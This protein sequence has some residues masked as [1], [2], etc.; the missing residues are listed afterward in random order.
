MAGSA[1]GRGR[2][3]EGSDYLFAPL[4]SRPASELKATFSPGPRKALN[5]RNESSEQLGSAEQ[6][7]RRGSSSTS[8]EGDVHQGVDQA[9]APG[10]VSSLSAPSVTG[11]LPP[12]ALWA[13]AGAYDPPRLATIA[14]CLPA[15]DK[16]NAAPPAPASSGPST[17]PAAPSGGGAVYRSVRSAK[18]RRATWKRASSMDAGGGGDAEERAIQDVLREGGPSASDDP[19]TAPSSPQPQLEAEG[20][21]RQVAGAVHQEQADGDVPLASI[22]VQLQQ[23]S[24]EVPLPALASRSAPPSLV[25]PPPRSSEDSDAPIPMASGMVQHVVPVGGSVPSTAPASLRSSSRPPTDSSAGGGTGTASVRSLE[26][27]E[28]ALRPQGQPRLDMQQ[29]GDLLMGTSTLTAAVLSTLWPEGILGDADSEGEEDEFVGGDV[30]SSS[31]QQNS[32]GAL[33]AMRGFLLEEFK[34]LAHL[35]TFVAFVP[36]KPGA[37]GAAE[38][39]AGGGRCDSGFPSLQG[40]GEGHSSDDGSVSECPSDCS[41]SC[42]CSGSECSGSGDEYDGHSS[43]EEEGGGVPPHDAH[44]QAHAPDIIT[45]RSISEGSSASSAVGPSPLAA[46]ARRQ[47][48]HSR[49]ALSPPPS[50][51]Q[52]TTPDTL[53]FARTTGVLGLPDSRPL[54]PEAAGSGGRHGDSTPPHNSVRLMRT[55]SAPIATPSRSPATPSSPFIGSPAAAFLL[56]AAH[57]STSS[58]TGVGGPSRGAGAVSPDGTPVVDASPVPARRASG[59]SPLQHPSLGRAHSSPDGAA[60]GAATTPHAPRPSP[61]AVAALGSVMSPPMIPS[62]FQTDPDA[63]LGSLSLGHSA[64]ASPAIQ[65][66]HAL[67]FG[68]GSAF[69]SARASGNSPAGRFSSRSNSLSP[70]QHAAPSA[71]SSDSPS[72]S[73][74]PSASPPGEAPLPQQRPSPGPSP[75]LQFHTGPTPPRSALH[76]LEHG[77]GDGSPQAA[78]GRV[79][80]CTPPPPSLQ[81]ARVPLSN[82]TGSNS[83]SP[84]HEGP[85]SPPSEATAPGPGG[86]SPPPPVK[87]R[88]RARSCSFDGTDMAPLGDAA[89]SPPPMPLKIDVGSAHVPLVASGSYTEEGSDACVTVPPSPRTLLQAMVPV[90][91]ALADG[92]AADTAPAPAMLIASMAVSSAINIASPPAPI[93]VPVVHEYS[94]AADT[95]NTAKEHTP[96]PPEVAALPLRVHTP[97]AALPE[98]HDF[99][100]G[101]NTPPALMDSASSLAVQRGEGCDR[102][103]NDTPGTP[104]AAAGGDAAGGAGG[105]WRANGARGALRSTPAGTPAGAARS[106]SGLLGSAS[107]LSGAL[108]GASPAAPVG[109]WM[110][111]KSFWEAFGQRV[112]GRWMWE[113]VDEPRGMHS[114]RF[115]VLKASFLRLPVYRLWITKALAEVSADHLESFLRDL[116]MRRQFGQALVRSREATAAGRMGGRRIVGKLGDGSYLVELLVFCTKRVSQE[117]QEVTPASPPGTN[118]WLTAQLELLARAL[119]NCARTRPLLDNH[120]D[121]LCDSIGDMVPARPHIALVLLQ[122][123]QSAWPKKDAGREVQ[124]LSITKT[125][126]LACPAPIVTAQRNL[127]RGMMRRV[128]DCLQ[129]DHAAVVRSALDFISNMYI[130]LYYLL[131]SAGTQQAVQR[132]LVANRSHWS[133]EV[134]EAS[135]VQFDQLL[136]YAY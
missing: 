18:G 131:P 114:Q 74:A 14:Q 127:T 91:A 93:T 32:Y 5:F 23:A 81:P 70:T 76:A 65:G 96:P 36:A 135:E 40:R 107:A 102:D 73:A 67:R 59:A 37:G 51:L 10:Q 83:G 71:A 111:T 117:C 62:P 103:W 60:A 99:G 110:P 90:S 15:F 41:G 19:D 45:A 126:L 115:E 136:E 112:L 128:I 11:A 2:D 34:T 52:G 28:E 100:A 88:G 113:I 39:A 97:P 121:A 120:F 119:V 124:W 47:L 26:E 8:D 86:L 22:P 78:L 63:P 24:D 4:P 89:V 20:T 30:F 49:S 68:G 84:P 108:P 53:P 106:D 125:V 98:E 75:V 95:G 42:C 79:G 61:Q 31:A 80:D 116:H 92:I 118:T 46:S 21:P 9:A 58:G 50:A 12:G 64:S 57:H 122:R 87:R 38:G 27:E 69:G 129:S 48:A 104:T 33:M 35:D 132:A 72:G 85:M 17:L 77:A 1:A 66:G 29:P 25:V 7:R 43:E 55:R 105:Q 13:G 94:G 82:S 54:S 44:T 130:R 134:R 6:L 101:H 123:F 109:Y 3:M 56:G 133:P 16:P